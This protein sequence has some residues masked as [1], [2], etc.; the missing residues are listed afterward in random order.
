MNPTNKHRIYLALGSNLGDREANLGAGLKALS[1]QVK[2]LRESPIYETA[3]W[4]YEEQEDFLNMVVEAETS[5]EPEALLAQL[6]AVEEAVGRTPTFRYGPREIDVDLL[7]YDDLVLET[8][9]LTIPHPHLHERAFVLVPLA[10]LAPDL[11]HPTLG[12][13]IKELVARVDSRGVV[14]YTRKGQP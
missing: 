14:L 12:R 7:F 9:E 1:P 10:N 3:P 13:M 5:L 2:I 8:D 4:G 11:R 6:K